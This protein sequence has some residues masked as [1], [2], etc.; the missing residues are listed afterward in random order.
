MPAGNCPECGESFKPSDHTFPVGEVRFCCPDCGQDYYGDGEGGHL[1]PRE[2]DCAQCGR[3]IHE[4]DCILLPADGGM[5][6]KVFNRSPWFDQS[7]GFIGRWLSTVGWSMSRPVD[8]VRQLPSNERLFGSGMAFAGMTLGFIF[9]CTLPVFLLMTLP[10]ILPTPGAGGGLKMGQGLSVM[11]MS[12]LGPLIM[13]VAIL[14]QGVLGHGCLIISGGAPHPIGRTVLVV[15][16][17]SGP[18]VLNGVPCLGGCL[19]P[20]TLVWALIISILMLMV[21]QGI[22]AGRAV[23]AMLLPGLIGLVLVLGVNFVPMLYMN[24]MAAP[25]V[26]LPAVPGAP[27]EQQ[28]DAE[29]QILTQTHGGLPSIEQFRAHVQLDPSVSRVLKQTV[30][31]ARC[32]GTFTQGMFKGWWLGDIFVCETN[33]M[34][35]ENLVVMYWANG[36]FGGNIIKIEDHGTNSSVVSKSKRSIGASVFVDATT[37]AT[38]LDGMKVQNERRSADGFDPLPEGPIIQ[39]WQEQTGDFRGGI[40]EDAS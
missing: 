20:V 18:M 5:D 23:F 34:M 40:L 12:V 16:F 30:G 1:R 11:G 7:R 13:L 38:F 31:N 35:Q 19:T 15:S 27:I 9:L 17:A 37:L 3:H 39:W 21:A 8:L 36:G 4:D 28:V 25:N 22:S 32:E 6:A 2:F 33:H 26:P 24:N 10:S 29:I 14:V